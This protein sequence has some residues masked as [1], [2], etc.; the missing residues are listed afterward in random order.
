MHTKQIMINNG[1]GI[2]IEFVKSNE[3]SIEFIDVIIEFRMWFIRI[4]LW[5]LLQLSS[6]LKML[7]WW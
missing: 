5:L 1:Q 3:E 6:L 4:L 2:Q 7:R